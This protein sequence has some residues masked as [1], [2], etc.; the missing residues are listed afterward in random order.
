MRVFEKAAEGNTWRLV[1]SDSGPAQPTC[2][3]G[4]RKG[5]IGGLWNL[6]GVETSD[7]GWREITPFDVTKLDTAGVFHEVPKPDPA[8][9]YFYHKDYPGNFASGIDEIGGPWIEF[10]RPDIANATIAELRARV[11]ELE[12]EAKSQRKRIYNLLVALGD[13]KDAVGDAIAER[14]EE[15]SEHEAADAGEVRV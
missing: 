15:P 2:I 11:A 4:P 10:P 12:A 9:R 1:L 6:R 3:D 14:F 7:W 8:W 13:I 5:A